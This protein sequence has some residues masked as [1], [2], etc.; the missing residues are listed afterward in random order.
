M[1]TSELTPERLRALAEIRPERGLVLSLYLNLDPRE[2]SA[3]DARHTAIRSLVADAERQIADGGLEHDEERGAREDIERVRRFLDDE[4]DADGAHAIA[5]FASAPAGLWETIKLARPVPS[6]VLV[7]NRALVEPLAELADTTRWA[8]LLANRSTARILRG[9]RDGLT[10]VVHRDDGVHGQHSRGG[11]SQ[12]RYERSVDRAAEDHVRASAQDLMRLHQRRPI[13]ALLL[14][15]PEELMGDVEGALHPYLR[16]RLAGRI[17]VDVEY[18]TPDDVLVAARE[19]FAE[20]GRAHEAGALDRLRAGIGAGGRA[21]GGWA[22]VLGTLNEKRVEIL[23]LARPDPTHP[24]APGLVCP[25]C[26]WLGLEAEACPVDGTGLGRREDIAEPAVEAAVRQ[27][28]EV[29]VLRH[30]DDALRVH[31]GVGAVLRF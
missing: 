10:E 7:D 3:P 22:D 4:L 26:G 6:T 17:V 2:F 21:V 25:V 30:H 16:E 8:V 20:H 12:A 28:A 11:W 19:A 9:S 23:L 27:H 31:G 1:Q 15:G 5:L 18:T 14:G 24:R 29:M 13:D